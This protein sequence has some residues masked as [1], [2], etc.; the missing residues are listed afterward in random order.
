MQHYFLEKKHEEL[1]LQESDIH[2]VLHVMRMKDNDKIIGIYAGKQYLCSLSIKN[3][4][5]K[6]L[7]EKELAINNENEKKIIL[8]QAVI[9]NDKF[10]LIVQ[11]ACELGVDSLVP[12][13]FKYSVVNVQGKEDNKIKRYNKIIKEACE[14]SHRNNLMKIEN[15]INLKDIKINEDTLA[16]MAYENEQKNIL[17]ENLNFDNYKNIAILIGPEGGI[18]SDEINYLTSI[19]FKSISLG[20]RIL[21]SETAAICS[22]SIINYLL[23][24]KN[25][26][27]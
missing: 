18:S 26:G 17:S 12:T 16:L 4:S 25:Y 5:I 19:G 3:N 14:Q 21:R 20:K 1:C 7:I 27:K 11:K 8:Y 23:E 15:Y 13:I 2:H 24:A 9:K 10:D 6:L 22:L